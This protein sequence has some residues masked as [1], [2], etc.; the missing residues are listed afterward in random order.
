[1]GVAKLKELVEQKSRGRIGVRV[2]WNSELGKERENAEMVRDG[3]I[4]MTT[5]LPA[6]AGGWIP[7]TAIVEFPYIYKDDAH[8]MRVMRAIRPHL[9][10]ILAPHNFTP[11]GAIDVGFRYVL[12]KQKPIYTVA[13]LK[14]MKIRVPNPFYSALFDALGARASVLPWADIYM[15][16]Q[17]GVIDAMEASPALI[18]SMR[19]YEQAKYLSKTNHIAAVICYLTNKKWFDGLP[20][21]LQQVMVDATEEA[22]AFQ[23][24][25]QSESESKAVAALQAA[26]TKVNDVK[27]PNEFRQAAVA[28]REKYVKEKGPRWEKL[29]QLVLKVE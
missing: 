13:D 10:E 11:L 2:W 19:F 23:F 29:Y 14:G 9:E 20:K 5:S 7:E 25:L 28:F 6:G 16:L 3:S 17:S 18:Q 15:G 8:I 21:D 27:D 24:K 1:M 4:E 22:T 26:G 12:N